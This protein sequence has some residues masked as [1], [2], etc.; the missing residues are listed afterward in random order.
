M[1]VINAS[2]RIHVTG[3]P[4]KSAGGSAVISRDAVMVSVFFVIR[5]VVGTTV[6]V[7]SDSSMT[8]W[9]ATQ[10]DI[11]FFARA[12]ARWYVSH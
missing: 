10:R 2:D 8:N 7:W 4:G 9:E 1:L 6:E 11:A 3:G 5:T 12:L